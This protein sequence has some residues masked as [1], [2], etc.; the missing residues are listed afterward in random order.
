MPV[1]VEVSE[2][3]M[4]RETREHKRNQRRAAAQNGA[5]RTNMLSADEILT[6]SKFWPAPICGIYFLI[7]SDRIIW[8]CDG[9]VILTL[10]S[11]LGRGHRITITT[12]DGRQR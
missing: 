5:Q 7:L 12:Y 1:D 9:D 4:P 10:P 8:A 6:A 11:P 3:E 2:G